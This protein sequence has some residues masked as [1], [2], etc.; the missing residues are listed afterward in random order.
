[1]EV[2]ESLI[3][4]FSFW[5]LLY[6]AKNVGDM[7]KYGRVFVGKKYKRHWNILSI[8]N[9]VLLLLVMWE[10]CCY[11]D[12]GDV[13][14][15]FRVHILYVVV[16]LMSGWDHALSLY[17]FRMFCPTTFG[18]KFYPN[19]QPVPDNEENILGDVI[20]RVEVDGTCVRV[21]AVMKNSLELRQQMQGKAHVRVKFVNDCFDMELMALENNVELIK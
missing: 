10:F 17:R 5:K 16:A 14:L 11:L 2:L 19:V 18:Y 6:H 4:V 8:T 7:L 9:F 15:G 1:M 3:I 12:Y 21:P 13:P 20:L